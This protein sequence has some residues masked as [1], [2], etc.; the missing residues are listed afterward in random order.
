[1][2]QVEG[3]T[4]IYG[5]LTG[6]PPGE[7]GFHIHEKGNPKDCCAGLGGHYN[8]YKTVHGDRCR[9]V[10]HVGD[11][12]NICVAA[13]GSVKIDVT[14]NQVALY[15]PTSVMGRSI[16]IHSDKDD[17]G[18]G[19]TPASLKN[20]NSGEMIAYGIIGYM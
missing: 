3:G 12:G 13:N 2:D 8:P 4:H 14:D 20:G 9:P 18:M 17:C 19:G 7:H 11:L 10:R 6:L 16:V 1:M 15:G 5:T